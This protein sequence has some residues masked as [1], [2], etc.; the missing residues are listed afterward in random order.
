MLA[1]GTHRIQLVNERLAY[2]AEVTLDVLPGEVT[3]H[4]VELPDGRLSVTADPWA[5]V[6]VDGEP[7]GRTPL[8]DLPVT[9]GT[10]SVIFSHPE[11]GERRDTVLVTMAG[12]AEVHAD[13][14]R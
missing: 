8:T 3:A 14:A 10:R 5:E 9:I 2:R 6:T 11:L 4:S 1:P 12:V 7:M 13:L